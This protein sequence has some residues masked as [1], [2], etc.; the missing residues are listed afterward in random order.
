MHSMMNDAQVSA[1][2]ERARRQ[3][4]ARV[5]KCFPDAWGTA[6]D[7]VFHGLGSCVDLVYHCHPAI[8][9]KASPRERAAT[10]CYPWP[11]E[12]A[13]PTVP[14][15][16]IPRASFVG[17]VY[18]FNY[19]RVVWWAEAMKRGLPIDFVSWL[20]GENPQADPE[21]GYQFS[22]TDFINALHGY[23]MSINFT[24]RA[25]GA[26]IL[27]GK[28]VEIPMAGGCLLEEHSVDAAYI[29][30]PGIHYLPFTSFA[31]LEAAI[32]TLL[33]DEPR[34]LRMV[35]AG[36]AWVMRYFSGDYFWA[37]LLTRLFG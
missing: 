3:Y 31:D 11:H 36:Q 21:A 24:R 32:E 5:V 10:W 25:T 12:I 15:G 4:G 34:R 7:R 37:G 8:L 14:Q 2:L 16:A 22:D 13:T 28:T 17:T 9:P 35:E 6:D 29:L 18:T 1:L 23:R 26:K 19:S 27:T 20:P 30:K 33:N